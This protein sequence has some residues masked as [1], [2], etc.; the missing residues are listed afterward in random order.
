ML[1]I[2]AMERQFSKDEDVFEASWLFLEEFCDPYLSDVDSAILAMYRAS[3]ELQK[4]RKQK[5]KV[6]EIALMVHEFENDINEEVISCL[7]KRYTELLMKI[8]NITKKVGAGDN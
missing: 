7:K 1:R 6:N 4:L 2:S 8:R 3:K 5:E